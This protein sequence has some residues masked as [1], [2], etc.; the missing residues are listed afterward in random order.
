M[1][2]DISRAA[3]YISY[4]IQTS[5]GGLAGGSNSSGD[6][7]LE[8]DVLSNTI[9]EQHLNESNLVCCYSSEEQKEMVE[10]SDD[11]KYS[12]VFDPLDGSSLVD[13]NFA[14]GSIVG[15]YEGR[16]IIGRK[17]SEQ[18]AAL[19]VLY[20]PRTILIY[21][22]GNGVHEFLLND[23]GEFILFRENI[24]IAD[25]AKNYSAGNL[26]ALSDNPK[27]DEVFHD[28]LKRELTLRYSGCMVADVHHI[29]A[30]GQGIFSNVGG[31]KYPDGKL[32]LVY[33]CGPLSF[34]AENAGGVSL[35]G[36]IRIM[37]KE[38]TDLH[39]RTQIIIGSKNEVE[40]VCKQLKET[41][42]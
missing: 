39:Q 10:L 36:N 6:D 25:K 42:E 19:Y 9:F 28:W 4:A 7:Q 26:R 11:A 24:G 20:G 22:T 3:K 13:A 2:N 1:I 38:I 30:K 5:E 14:I 21:S 29:F 34:L 32:R 23:V 40:K 16:E 31:S 35:D 33:E 8:L 41:S 12:V 27:Y 15:I 17:P 37:D 18:V